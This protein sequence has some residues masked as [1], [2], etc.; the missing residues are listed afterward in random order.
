MQTRSD[1]VQATTRRIQA[2]SIGDQDSAKYNKGLLQ[3]R[4]A[5]TRASGGLP[6]GNSR[7]LRNCSAAVT[8]CRGIAERRLGRRQIGQRQS[9]RRHLGGG[10]LGDG[11][12]GG[13]A[14]GDSSLC[15]IILDNGGLGGAEWAARNGRRRIGS[16]ANWERGNAVRQFTGAV[17]LPGGGLGGGKWAADWAA[18]FK[19]RRIVRRRIGRPRIG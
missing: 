15:G 14:L 18:A 1:K 13:D 8:Q 2:V 5:R 17:E 19:R 12:V 16:V 4:T 10:G 9:G 6:H 7:I 11:G 3:E